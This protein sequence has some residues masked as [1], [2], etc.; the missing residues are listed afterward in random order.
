MVPQWCFLGT[1]AFRNTLCCTH[2]V[3]VVA[4]L[5]AIRATFL[6]NLSTCA[7]DYRIASKSSDTLPMV[8]QWCFL[9]TLAFRNTLCCTHGVAVVACL[10]AFRATFLPNLSTCA[11]DY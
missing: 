9:G 10:G 8:P 4:C 6:P 1:L 2:G 5:G 3:A 11:L 7:L